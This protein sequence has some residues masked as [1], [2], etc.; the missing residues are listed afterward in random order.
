MKR[1]LMIQSM[2]VA[3]PTSSFFSRPCRDDY[4]REAF[5]EIEGLTRP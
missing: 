1:I 2:K 3:Y 4:E 5:V